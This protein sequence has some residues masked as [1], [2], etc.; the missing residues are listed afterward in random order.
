MRKITLLQILFLFS[1]SIFA[2]IPS[3]YYNAAVG[4]TEAALKTQ[5][6]SIISSVYSTKS[7][8]Y[9]YTIYETSDLNSNGKVWVMYSTCTWTPGVK[10][11]GNY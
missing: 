1:I 9:L 5:L 4:K 7:Y 3:G 8:D 10:K 2:Q 6:Y 11:C